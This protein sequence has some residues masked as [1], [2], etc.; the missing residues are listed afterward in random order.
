MTEQRVRWAILGTG[1]IATTFA[2][3]LRL[4]P[5][6]TSLTYPNGG[7]QH[8]ATTEVYGAGWEEVRSRVEAVA[9][10]VISEV[11]RDPGMQRAVQR[12]SGCMARA[13]TPFVDLQAPREAIAERLQA[14]Q[15]TREA[16]I[17][18]GRGEVAT[19]EADAACQEEVDLASAVAAA[20]DRVERRVVVPTLRVEVDRY[21]AMKAT[22][23]DRLSTASEVRPGA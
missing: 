7:C 22:A 16:A 1:G 5:D 9:N 18:V 15:L 23:L 11:E 12:W 2:D 14:G 13:G 20:Q 10:M 6:G 19:A 4:L 17:D 3:D 8:N 21:A